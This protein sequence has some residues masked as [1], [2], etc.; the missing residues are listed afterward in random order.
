M[1]RAILPILLGLSLA[2]FLCW[3]A[4]PKTDEAKAIAEIE[5]LGGTIILYKERPGTPAL[6][7]LEGCEV[8]DAWL[9]HL[10]GLP[11]V[12]VL[13]LMA[14]KVTDTGL[15]RL[16]GLTQLQAL[17]LPTT[18]SDAGLVHLKGL[19]Q[20]RTLELGFSKVTDAGL[21]H[22]K[23]LTRLQSLG[24][25]ATKVTDAGLVHLEG[26]SK[27]QFLNLLGTEVTDAG[28]IHLDS[29]T[30][31]Q[32]LALPTRVSDKGLVDLKKLSRLQSLTLSGVNCAGPGKLGARLR[33]KMDAL[34]R[35]SERIQRWRSDGVGSDMMRHSRRRWP[36]QQFVVTR[37]SANWRA[38]TPCMATW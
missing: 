13:N 17:H 24:L 5:K 33:C 26:L 30:Q 25:R 37:R 34:N 1:N 12:Q 4:E 32:E 23:G 11:N 14:T 31:L 35:V 19:S 22:L 18:V 10:K 15:V 36:W 3:A 27:L 28:L 38:S 29:L 21:V 9:E 7:M 20:L 8:T 16:K 6:V 2:P